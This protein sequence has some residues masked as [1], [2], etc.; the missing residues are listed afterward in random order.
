MIEVPITIKITPSN[1]IMRIL[2]DKNKNNFYNKI[3]NANW[4]RLYTLNDTNTAFNYFI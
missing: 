3:Q 1:I 2:S 4:T